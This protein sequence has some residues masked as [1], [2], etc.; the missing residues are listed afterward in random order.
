MHSL[1]TIQN[2]VTLLYSVKLILLLMAEDR[3]PFA[4]SCGSHRHRVML[5][6]AQSISL[7]IKIHIT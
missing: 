3:R 7:V 5:A 6:A 2:I 4:Q 1:Y